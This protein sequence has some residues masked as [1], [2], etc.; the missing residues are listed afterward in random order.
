M[1]EELKSSQFTISPVLS[2]YYAYYK[3]IAGLKISCIAFIN[4][5]QAISFINHQIYFKKLPMFH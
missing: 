3:T 5:G 4:L 2:K 1:V